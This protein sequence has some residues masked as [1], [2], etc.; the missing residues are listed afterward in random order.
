MPILL[1]I[2][3][4]PLAFVFSTY[5][6]QTF[7]K[8]IAI[9][10]LMFSFLFSIQAQ[11][12]IS[13]IENYV[14]LEAYSAELPKYSIELD[15]VH[16]AVYYDL[17]HLVLI[18]LEDKNATPIRYPLDIECFDM[19]F[20]YKYHVR[21]ENKLFIWSGNS[22]K[23]V[24]LENPQ[25][26]SQIDIDG[27]FVSPFMRNID[28]QYIFSYSSANETLRISFINLNTNEI[29]NY[30]YPGYK[31][32]QITENK[33]LAMT[34]NNTALAVFNQETEQLT[35]IYTGSKISRYFNLSGSS[36]DFVFRDTTL[37]LM[38]YQHS[39]G[40]IDTICT[41]NEA[42]KDY[43]GVNLKNHIVLGQGDPSTGLYKLIGINKSDCIEVF[44]ISNFSNGLD[45]IKSTTIDNQDIITIIG[46]DNVLI[47]NT[48]T[49]QSSQYDIRFIS[50]IPPK[51]LKNQLLFFE[52]TDIID[53]KK[54]NI[55][56]LVSGDRKTQNHRIVLT[57]NR[58][59]ITD[60]LEDSILIISETE[61]LLASINLSK[62]STDYSIR[63]LTIPVDIG[64]RK[65]RE[66]TRTGTSVTSRKDRYN[67]E[68]LVLE[69]I[70]LTA[71]ENLG[72]SEGYHIWDNLLAGVSDV[73]S[74]SY[75]I[76]Y[77]TLT[78]KIIE[79]QFLS[80]QKP[81]SRQPIVKF[82][83][84]YYELKNG[85]FI[86]RFPLSGPFPYPFPISGAI[87]FEP[88]PLLQLEN[89]FFAIKKVNSSNYSI[90]KFANNQETIVKSNLKTPY[91]QYTNLWKQNNPIILYAFYQQDI[92]ETYLISIDSQN[93]EIMF[94]ESYAGK[95][96][97]TNNSS[98][99]DWI[100]IKFQKTDG[101]ANV[102]HT[103]GIQK[104]QF[105]LPSEFHESYI[106][107]E[108]FTA[109]DKLLIQNRKGKL[110]IFDEQV[111]PLELSNIVDETETIND[112]IYSNNQYYL[113]V[114]SL[115]EN[116]IIILSDEFT[117][118]NE[119]NNN[120]R[121]GCYNNKS[122]FIGTIDKDKFLFSLHTEETGSEL[123]TLNTLT[124]SVDIFYEFNSTH[125]SGF[126]SFEFLSDGYAYVKGKD[127]DKNIQM[128]RIAL[129]DE[130]VSTEEIILSNTTVLLS[131]NP[132][133]SFITFNEPL[134][135]VI[136]TSQSGNV[137]WSQSSKNLIRTI[138][139]DILNSG[140]YIL[141]GISEQQIGV[142]SKFIKI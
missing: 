96:R 52:A 25:E 61:Y 21:V 121:S 7:M 9:T 63:D 50:L 5:I 65:R 15:S 91:Y 49:G 119:I 76:I 84:I 105:D 133:N 87:D 22:L 134:R 92:D 24:N 86:E 40:V 35:N 132:S 30:E 128:Y 131:P 88:S 66:W 64:L 54:L 33:I 90:R 19:S 138:D 14:Q 137:V 62:T 89:S 69:N 106:N 20:N 11:Q 107:V 115:I 38:R 51:I 29:K 122:T 60:N 10:L 12:K 17:S 18:N 79:Q 28:D 111:A 42:E 103:N 120:P 39:T 43:W 46:Q 57:D 71:K 82:N 98:I 101:T 6:K 68:H 36:E 47:Y 77:N 13:D 124:N 126:I 95:Y 93:G 70:K 127:Q 3:D 16:Y 41:I 104:S 94:S 83:N 67:E 2:I 97:I 108:S 74:A 78:D 129:Y 81:S 59:L 55:I 140:L 48:N 100:T 80:D 27:N 23:I 112:L 113:L 102:L 75:F 141:T 135:N 117:F 37:T 116:K 123:W 26:Q 44:D 8:P 32:Q 85:R 99:K 53:T 114:S 118:I 34:V 125:M 58:L 4:I 45:I 56:D 1:S 139:I 136:I 142:T 72:L 110:Y 73:D 31:F 130:S 109:N